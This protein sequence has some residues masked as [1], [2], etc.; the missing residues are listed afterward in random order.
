MTSL[1]RYTQE[2][3]TTRLSPGAVLH[4][5]LSPP[6]VRR[7]KGW[8]WK[9]EKAGESCSTRS[10]YVMST[11]RRP[12]GRASEPIPASR[13]NTIEKKKKLL[14]VR[15]RQ[16][17]RRFCSRS[18]TYTHEGASRDAAPNPNGVA[19]PIKKS[20]SHRSAADHGASRGELLESRLDPGTHTRAWRLPLQIQR[21]PFLTTTRSLA[22]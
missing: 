12:G 5:T 18:F 1:L 20:V 10:R 3:H 6:Q 4:F 2:V 8:G 15:R 14:P 11:A 19:T 13:K 16:Q 21:A 9:L 7:R 17:Q 22:S